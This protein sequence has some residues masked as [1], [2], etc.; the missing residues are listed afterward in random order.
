MH[1]AAH[2]SLPD[3]QPL[4]NDAVVITARQAGQHL[5]FPLGEGFDP[6]AWV[7]G[8]WSLVRT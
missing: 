3:P 7:D 4:G 2:G 1:V 8:H 6:L 5:L